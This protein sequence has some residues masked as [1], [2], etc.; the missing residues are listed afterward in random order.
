MLKDIASIKTIWLVKNHLRV[1]S[2]IHGQMRRLQKSLDLPAHPWF[3]DLIQLAR[4]DWMGR[5]GEWIVVYDRKGIIR[6]LNKIAEG[7]FRN[8]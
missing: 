4:W 5:D 3:V 1:K 2:Y 6:D 7:H 8:G